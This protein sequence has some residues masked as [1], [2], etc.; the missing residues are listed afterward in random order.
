MECTLE[1]P[2]CSLVVHILTRDLHAKSVI[3]LP[4]AKQSLIGPFDH[5]LAPSVLLCAKLNMTLDYVCSH[6]YS[7]CG[8]L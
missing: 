7:A 1:L 5:P 3:I 2:T 6:N 4:K 8:F